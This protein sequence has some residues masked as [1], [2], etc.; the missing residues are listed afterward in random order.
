MLSGI[1]FQSSLPISEVLVFF[2][3]LRANILVLSKTS[4]VERMV[5]QKVDCREI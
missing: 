1:F 4:L 3:T 5:A 2:R